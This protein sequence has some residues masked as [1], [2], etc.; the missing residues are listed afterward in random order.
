MIGDP[1][2]SGGD[3]PACY[4]G[5]KVLRNLRDIVDSTALE[6]FEIEA[7]GQRS[8]QP[9][10]EGDFNAAH[11]RA[12]HKHLFQDVYV[13]AGEYRTIRTAKGGNWFC[14]PEHI[15]GQMDALFARL[16]GASFLPGGDEES[17]IA[18]LADFVGDLNAIHPFRE[19]NG[20]TQL[21]F[22]R[23]LG[24]RAGHPLRSEAVE[25]DAFLRAMIDSFHGQLEALIDELERML[26]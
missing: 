21:H 5:T 7:V 13:W 16:G 9:P 25:R 8:L 14:Y 24:L 4:P 11:Y 23:L 26:A 6:E 10:P 15:G 17:F 3:D 1:Y 18:G 19:G 12:L 2:E 22:A 20:R